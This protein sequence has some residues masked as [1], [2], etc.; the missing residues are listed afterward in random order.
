MT[1]ATTIEI[2][3]RP[4]A[5]DLPDAA[6]LG[7]FLAGRDEAAFEELV[8]RHGP[9]VLRTCR[10]R[11]GVGQDAEDACQATFL[12]L[13]R[14]AGAIRQVDDVGAW[15]RGVARRVA[16]REKT[17]ADRD[18][19]RK[20]A[21]VD[22]GGVAGREEAGFDEDLRPTIR[23]EVDRLPEK[24]RRPI[25]L[26]YWEGLSNDQAAERLDCPTGT[27][28]WRL[29]R[30]RD[31]LRDRFARRGIA[32]SALLIGWRRGADGAPTRGVWPRPTPGPAGGDREDSVL[33]DSFVRE[34]V[35]LAVF[36][37]DS[38]PPF[39]ADRAIRR[40]PRGDKKARRSVKLASLVA[41]LATLFGSFSALALSRPSGIERRAARSRAGDPVAAARAAAA[42][43]EMLH[44]C[45][46]GAGDRLHPQPSSAVV[47]GL[48][49]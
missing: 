1:R 22:I 15:L 18:R 24:Y 32:L 2:A 38:P 9:G 45:Q 20:G 26:C 8:R 10:R 37:R 25:E 28:K 29:S 49:P 6:L 13:V 35:A 7:R 46:G 43:E 47:K 33:S 4:A 40:L 11:L 17:R 30:G 39:L 16:A 21:A 44:N 41:L 12:V 3:P 5:N 27:V 48:M 42:R 19:I 36:V 34:T 14:R 31:L 23:A